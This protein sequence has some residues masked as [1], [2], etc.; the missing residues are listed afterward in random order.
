MAAQNSKWSSAPQ[1]ARVLSKWL[2]G[3]VASALALVIIAIVLL[4][5]APL[6]QQAL[7][8]AIGTINQ[9]KTQI[10]IGDL[11][12]EWPYHLHVSD[13]TLA[14]AH[15]VWLTLAD[16]DIRWSP[17]GLFRGTLHITDFSARGLDV[18]RA[19]IS[20][21][22]SQGIPD[23][24]FAFPTSPLNIEIE[25]GHVTDVALG[26]GLVTSGASGTLARLD[27]TTTLELARNR[28]DFLLE[29]ARKDEVR[30]SLNLKAQIDQRDRRIAITLDAKDG[31]HDHP[32]L[33]SA[34]AGSDFGPLV[35]AARINGLDGQVGGNIHID[36]GQSLALDGDAKGQ[37]DRELNLD[38]DLKTTG[39]LIA[40]ALL[41]I[42]G[43]GDVLTLT[44]AFQWKNDDTISLSKIDLRADALALTG[45]LSL[46]SVSRTGK[47][48]LTGDG[49]LNGLDTVLNDRGNS[50]LAAMQWNIK[51]D[52]D[53]AQNTADV[54]AFQIVSS[55]GHAGFSGEVGLDGS[56]IKGHAEAVLSDLAPFSNLAGM[57]LSG[58]A[59]MALSPFVREK[60]GSTAGDF[61]IHT[62]DVK[63]DDPV[64]TQL[65]NTL[66]ADGS[67]L[68]PE[69]GGFALPSFSV[70]PQSGS[71]L[72]QGNVAAT[73]P[74]ILTGQAHFTASDATK[75]L[76]GYNTTGALSA[77]LT[78]SGTTNAPNAKL[79]AELANGTL[80]G[81]KTEKLRLEAT[82]LHDGTGPVHMSFKGAPGNANLDAQLHLPKAGGAELSAINGD[83]FGSKISGQV[84]LDDKGLVTA[85]IDGEHVILTPLGQFVDVAMSGAGTLSLKAAPANGKQG[86][87][88]AFST[89]RLDSS[90]ITLDRVTLDADLADLFG[91]PQIE[92]K[93]AAQSGQMNLIHLDGV[94]ASVSGP[95]DALAIKLDASG[96]NETASPKKV[97]LAL[98]AQMKNGGTN[99][100]DLNAFKLALGD[101]AMTLAKPV[102][103]NL[104]NGLSAQ[105]MRLDM[106]GASGAGSLTGDIAIN[107]TAQINLR[108]TSMPLDL[109]ALV[110]PVDSIH[111]S[112]EGA[113]TL[114]S[115][116]TVGT[117]ALTFDQVSITQDIGSKNPAFNARLDGKWAKTRL[118]LAAIAEG[119]STQPFNFKASLPFVRQSGSPFPM[120]GTRGPMT[121]SLD[122]DGPLA[123]LASLAE[124]DG[125]R[126]SGEAKV[127]LR[128]EG[129]ISAPVANGTATLTNGTYENFA[130]GTILKQL[131]VKLAG[132]RS[133]SLDFDLKGTDG[134]EGHISAQGMISLDKKSEQAIS[135]SA[136]IDNAHLLRRS[137]VDATLDGKLELTGPA[138]PPSLAEPVT[139]K[140]AVTTRA[141]HIRIPESLPVSVPLVEVVEINGTEAQNTSPVD[142]MTPLPLN[143]DLTFKIGPPARISGR[144]LDSLWSGQ[145]AVTGRA[146][147]PAIKGQLNS[148]RGTLDFIGK[149]FTLNKGSVT[150]PGTYP[151]DPT[152]NVTLAYARDDF[153]ATIGASGDTTSPKID[154]SSSPSYPEDEILSRI[155]FDKG[156][157]ELSPMEAVQLARALAEMSGVSIGGSGSGFLNRMQETLSLDV[158]RVDSSSSGATTV[159][160][161]KYIQKGIYVGVEQGALASDSSVKVEV[162]VTPQISV[163]TRIGQNATSDV[164]VTWKWDY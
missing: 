141:M 127:A 21:A 40:D 145:V 134:G 148:E 106:S 51:A 149:T 75:V 130:S 84:R 82:A 125:Q 52:V 110:L 85:N 151:I 63:M 154:L 11:T 109:A 132:H 32:G 111:G 159:S 36:S 90:G 56:S 94:K 14:D 4:Q 139:L 71:Y 60:N 77:E 87:Q 64:L 31:D 38:L 99:I 126:V 41:G 8:Y 140:G 42:G 97:S 91:T 113:M 37:W 95:L 45:Q 1:A 68:L 115:R 121:A 39:R 70:R 13:V 123:S 2:L 25:S 128:A 50:A 44:S 55:A 72:L 118:D 112:A 150:F 136:S 54:R 10:A 107:S 80:K 122:W 59:D 79:V 5:I 76:P 3:A 96:R 92:A 69:D 143:L 33:A 17:L 120:L 67:L 22:P 61:S 135:I 162:E 102:S 88:L 108:L 114:D 116:K 66:S 30:G 144:G 12:G 131:D 164:G 20:D 101:A 35:V 152:F 161:G 83:V 62:A 103:V 43:S 19:P 6:R 138:F 24:P 74:G 157:G 104:A 146:D 147:R 129:D 137:D 15:G 86:A 119:V 158:L 133:Q 46:G 16:A 98:D 81:T 163:D 73:A 53:L 65:A 100:I 153:T 93:L 18:A 156:V 23:S 142:G 89:S 47:H 27:L 57:R 105:G 29:I 26:R 7:Q 124:L 58:R 34:F 78:L 9:G 48:V 49:A 117:L 155:L 28:L 160:A